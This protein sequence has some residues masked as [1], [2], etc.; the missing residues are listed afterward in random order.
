[1]PESKEVKSL[2]FSVVTSMFDLVLVLTTDSRC[3]LAV[4]RNAVRLHHH[5][6]Q[7]EKKNRAGGEV[8]GNHSFVHE[9][10]RNKSVFM[11]KL[12]IGGEGRRED[13]ANNDIC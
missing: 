11:G 2:D 1:M 10:E 9:L 6:Y 4:A 3:H 12:N 7:N 8:G 5:Q 13:A